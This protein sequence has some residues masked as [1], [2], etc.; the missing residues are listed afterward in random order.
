MKQELTKWLETFK[1]DK[2]GTFTFKYNSS[3]DSARRSWTSFI[4]QL[5]KYDPN[6]KFFM[7]IEGSRFKNTHIHA[8]LSSSLAPRY[9]QGAWNR[10]RGI[11]K[12][13]A[14]KDNSGGVGYVTKHAYDFW[15]ID[16]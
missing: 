8:L 12:V 15:D 11:S 2:M 13:E 14:F 4:K 5:K 6:I 1:W 3:V 10:F 9:I 16:V 7:N